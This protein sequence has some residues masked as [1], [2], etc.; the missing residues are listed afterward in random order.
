MVWEFFGIVLVV[1]L[2]AYLY[3][4]TQTDQI[5]TEI[6]IAAEPEAV[7]SVLTD[8]NKYPEWNPFIKKIEGEAVVGEQLDATFHPL[9]MENP[10]NLKLIIQVANENEELRWLGRILIPGLLEGEQYFLLTET[11]SGTRF[12][13]GENFTGLLLLFIDVSENA[14]SFE[15]V[16]RELKVR[17]EAGS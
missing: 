7:W 14:P 2:G 12:T 10:Q 16:N 9:H 11:E 15:A 8:F 13:H 4:L 17:T 5:R 3:G 6:E 1:S